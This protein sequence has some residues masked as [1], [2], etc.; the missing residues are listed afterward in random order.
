MAEH[1]LRSRLAESPLNWR[2]SSAGT[3]AVEH[4]GI[5]P[6]AAKILDRMGIDTT[7]FR[8]RR[9]NRQLIGEADLILTA[10]QRQRELIAAVEP[11]A[12]RRTFP[13]LQF[14]RFVDDP[15]RD[16]QL[17]T[18]QELLHLALEMQGA[19]QPPEQSE[20]LNDPVGGPRRGYR[21]CADLIETAVDSILGYTDWR[22]A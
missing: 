21:V 15:E 19:S 12:R 10:E 11:A 17:R 9:V 16:G 2:I 1:I 3:H 7:G 14:A 6:N 5:M 20:D 13:L 8:S 22:P 18:G 4:T